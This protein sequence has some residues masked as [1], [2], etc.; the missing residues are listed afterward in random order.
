MSKAIYVEM[1][2]ILAVYKQR[3]SIRSQTKALS[4][5]VRTVRAE[6]RMFG[7]Y[8]DCGPGYIQEY[9]SIRYTFD[10]LVK[11]KI[12]MDKYCKKLRCEFIEKYPEFADELLKEINAQ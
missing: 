5:R 1:G 4:N 10:E 3:A 12:S 6:V 8:D 9:E 7:M 11:Q 2:K